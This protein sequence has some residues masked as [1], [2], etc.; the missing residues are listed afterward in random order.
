MVV[1]IS[2]LGAKISKAVTT[3]GYS[4]KQEQ[5]EKLVVAILTWQC[6]LT[7]PLY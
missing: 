7:I 4:L 3:W 1:S 6:K 5:K 2:Q